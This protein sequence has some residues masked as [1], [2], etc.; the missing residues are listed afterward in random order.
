MA[1]GSDLSPEEFRRLESGL[2]VIDR[3]LSSYATSHGMSLSKN[4]HNWP[5]R[6]LKWVENNNK[7][8]QIFL[9]DISNQKYNLWIVASSDIG[10]KRLWR[11]EF[12]LKDVP[13]SQIES[14]LLTYLDKAYAILNA[15]NNDDLY[16]SQ[17]DLS[18]QSRE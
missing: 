13:M 18:W 4:S 17:A 1:N 6:S 8:I 5:E 12:L 10:N 14:G 3:Q 9:S 2:A 11:E 15:W 16:V 7:L